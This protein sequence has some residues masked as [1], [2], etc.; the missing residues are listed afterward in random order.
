ML[1]LRPFG[2]RHVWLLKRRTDAE[3]RMHGRRTG[4]ADRSYEIRWRGRDTERGGKAEHI[5]Q[6]ERLGL[7]LCAVPSPRGMW[8]LSIYGRD[9]GSRS[10]EGIGS[11]VVV[12]TRRRIRT[13][14]RG[15]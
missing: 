6:G 13:E 9:E 11:R 7:S 8:G 5:M 10:N 4:R 1:G 3:C 14:F 15:G 12:L 2:V